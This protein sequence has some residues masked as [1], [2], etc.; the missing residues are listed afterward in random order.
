MQLSTQAFTMQCQRSF[1]SLF[2]IVSGSS[3]KDRN[4]VV[5]KTQT[6]YDFIL[7]LLYYLFK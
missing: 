7:F 1:S 3:S 4:C 6:G 5:T 2:I